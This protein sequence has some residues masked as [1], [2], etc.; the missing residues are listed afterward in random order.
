MSFYDAN[1][2]PRMTP[3]DHPVAV[4]LVA[5]L[6]VSALSTSR[7]EENCLAAPNARA[8][9]GSHWYYR[10]DPSSQNKCWHVRQTDEQSIQQLKPDQAG[11][12][13]AATPPPLPKPAPNGLKQHSNTVPTDQVRSGPSVGIVDLGANQS[14]T[15]LRGSLSGGTAAWPPPPAPATNANVWGDAPSGTVTAPAPSS[16]NSDNA[17]A[18][19]ST[20]PPDAAE[21]NAGTE[22]SLEEKPNAG[23]KQ[24]RLA[25]DN[26]ELENEALPDNEASYN[27]SSLATL[28]IIVAGVIVVGIFIRA[29]VR[30]G[31]ARREDIALEEPSDILPAEAEKIQTSEGALRGLL[32]ILEHEHYKAHRSANPHR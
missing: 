32:Q 24:Q 11:A 18:G 29:L 3:K 14:G 10:T 12:S 30:I 17:L 21:N 19:P 27:V 2:Q 25:G 15:E 26:A 8:P 9:Q 6:L 31:F 22:N 28:F 7:A 16:A 1:R 20:Q 4:L 23:L 5:A 13:A